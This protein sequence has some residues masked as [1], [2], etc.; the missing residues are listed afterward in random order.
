MDYEIQ[1]YTIRYFD[2]NK[3]SFEVQIHNNEEPDKLTEKYW[4]NM[5]TE[6]VVKQFEEDEYITWLFD[7]FTIKKLIKMYGTDFVEYL[8][9]CYEMKSNDRKAT[10]DLMYSF[11]MEEVQ[12]QDLQDYTSNVTMSSRNEREFN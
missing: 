4:V 9:Q 10:T 6:E 8:I 5:E 2:G 11:D 1:E 3:D 12:L 7:H